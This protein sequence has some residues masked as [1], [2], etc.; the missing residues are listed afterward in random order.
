MSHPI[1]H[2]FMLAWLYVTSLT[3]LII[4]SI[5][6]A[7][8]GKLIGTSSVGCEMTLTALSHACL[9]ELGNQSVLHTIQ[10]EDEIGDTSLII[11]RCKFEKHFVFTHKSRDGVS[12]DTKVCFARDTINLYHACI[13]ASSLFV[14]IAIATL[15]AFCTSRLRYARRKITDYYNLAGYMLM[16]TCNPLN[17]TN[18]NNSNYQDEYKHDDKNDANNDDEDDA[19]DDDN[20]T[21]LPNGL[22]RDDSELHR[23]SATCDVGRHDCADEDRLMS[24]ER[25]SK[26]NTRYTRMRE[27]LEFLTV[28]DVRGTHFHHCSIG[29]LALRYTDQIDFVCILLIFIALIVTV[30]SSSMVV[31]RYPHYPHAWLFYLPMIWSIVSFVIIPLAIAIGSRIHGGKSDSSPRKRSD[32]CGTTTH[33]NN[34]TG[35]NGCRLFIATCAGVCV[36]MVLYRIFITIVITAGLATGMYYLSNAL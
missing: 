19:N 8:P 15:N 33:A 7:S 36:G 18:E 34:S 6:L 32:A 3:I 12:E 24:L 9:P 26:G 5:V 20:W 23:R 31:R 16:D 30:S 27:N 14:V 22:P 2:V 1:T 29:G 13:I 28:D 25:W 35:D 10:T 21:F 11:G 4:Y 17:K